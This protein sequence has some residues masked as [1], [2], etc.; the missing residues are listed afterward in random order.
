M[1]FA[2]LRFVPAIP[3][4]LVGALAALCVLAL[5]P[6]LWRRARGSV[7]RLLC[8]AVVLL[9]LAGPRLVQEAREALGDIA[10]LVVDHTGSMATGHRTALTDAATAKLQA[11]AAA[12]PGMELRTMTVPEAGHDGTRL[13]TAMDHALAE[14]TPSWF[15]NGE[16]Q[17]VR[18]RNC[19]VV[20]ELLI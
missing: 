19:L 2:S 13:F 16:Q 14:A 1:A 5:A 18:L 4:W 15:G 9:W 3:L 6:A 8:F 12:I 20:P 17:R 11:E 10:V 7:L